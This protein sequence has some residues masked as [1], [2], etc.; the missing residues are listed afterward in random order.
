MNIFQITF[1]LS[2]SCLGEISDNFQRIYFAVNEK[3]ITVFFL[4]KVE[5]QD[6]IDDIKFEIMPDFEMLMGDEED[7]EDYDINCEIVIGAEKYLKDEDFNILVEFY[8]KKE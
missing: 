4:L 3:D 6:E 2:R 5:N 8:R 7:F 1:F